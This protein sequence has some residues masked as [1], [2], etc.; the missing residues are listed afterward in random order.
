MS[1]HAPKVDPI[2][3]IM[4]LI[5]LLAIV[6]VV[7]VLVSSL[8]STY[9]RNSVKGE[10]DTTQ[11]IMK[12]EG[13]LKPIGISSL[14]GAPVVGAAGRGGK[15]IY[16]AVCT[17]CHTT[18]VLDSPKL[19]DK[20][21]W[22]ARAAGGLDA[23]LANATNGKG[24]MP[25]KGGDPSLT[26][27]EIRTVV[28]YITKES[29]LDLGGAVEVKKEAPA[30]EAP[31]T[32]KKVEEKPA[33]AIAPTPAKAPESQPAPVVPVAA[34]APVA[35]ATPK[36]PSVDGKKVYDSACFAC[37]ASGVAGSPKLGDKAAW[38]PRIATGM[39]A[40]YTT[41]LKGKGAMPPKGGNMALADD[42]V[43]AAV[44]YMVS[45]SK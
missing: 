22:E 39:E 30:T 16:D 5:S 33:T 44:D 36:A 42:K 4:F 34:A 23:L 2:A 27:A 17:A 19:G 31:K 9:K 25:A 20:A 43:K 6:A 8:I 11:L 13:N 15:E 21:A 12:V 32:E 24:S 29:G 38:A 7:Y 18:G 41:S 3:K 28:L 40:L 45:Q 10:V 14:S 37:H 35:A 26:D 1:S